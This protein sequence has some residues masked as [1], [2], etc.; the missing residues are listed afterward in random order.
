MQ[1]TRASTA[2]NSRPSSTI[3]PRDVGEV[4]VTTVTLSRAREPAVPGAPQPGEAE[5]EHR[6][7][8]AEGHRR[9]QADRRLTSATTTCTAKR[10]EQRDL[11]ALGAVAP[12]RKNRP[13]MLDRVGAAAA[14]RDA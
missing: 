9:V 3:G 1:S 2:G 5:P 8:D 13:P 10:P 14:D 12:A 7:E 11:H 6:D 4:D